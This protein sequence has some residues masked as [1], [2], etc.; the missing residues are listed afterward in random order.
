MDTGHRRCDAR[1]MCPM[2][3]AVVFALPTFGFPP[4][5]AFDLRAS[6]SLSSEGVTRNE[7]RR[8]MKIVLLGAPPLSTHCFLRATVGRTEARMSRSSCGGHLFRKVGRESRRGCITCI[9]VSALSC[10]GKL[11]STC[12]ASRGIVV[13]V[14]VAAAAV[15]VGSDGVGVGREAQ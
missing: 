9:S 7:P 6:T 14:V 12:A 10:R 13:V 1:E 5:D 4:G 15:V 8:R 2:L 3:S 11:P